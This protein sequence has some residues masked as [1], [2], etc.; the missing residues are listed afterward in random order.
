MWLKLKTPPLFLINAKL[1]EKSMNLCEYTYFGGI[2]VYV[3]R[4]TLALLFI[5][6]YRFKR[7]RPNQGAGGMPHRSRGTTHTCLQSLAPESEHANVFRS[8]QPEKGMLAAF[9]RVRC[10]TM[11]RGK[12][13]QRGVMTRADTSSSLSLF[14]GVL[15]VTLWLVRK[16]Q[17]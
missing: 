9:S 12:M 4:F 8:A 5:C 1:Q 10:C 15:L 2:C 11:G 14:S 6:F 17:A 3:T 7:Q 16:P 13:E